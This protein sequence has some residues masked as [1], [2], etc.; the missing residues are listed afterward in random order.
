MHRNNHRFFYGYVVACAGFITWFIGWGAYAL[1]FGVFFKPLLAEFHWSR[2]EIS[3]AYSTAL[4]MQASL[5]IVMGWLTDRLGP[6]FVVTFFG[7]FLGW[8]FL[9]MSRVETLWQ[10]ILF[11]GVVGGIG[12]STLNIPIMATISRWFV[13]RRG[14]VTGLVQAGAGIGGFLLAPLSGW[15]IVHYGWRTASTILG[16]AIASLM[17][18]AGLFLI[19]DPMDIGLFPDGIRPETPA[20]AGSSNKASQPP[21]SSK[22]RMFKTAPFWMLA[23][24][25]AS[26]GY[27]RS[28]F[29]THIAVHVQDLGFSLS[30][31]AHILA[32]IAL[33]SI[34][35]RIGMGRLG[36]I[37]GTKRTVTAS[38]VLTSLVIL[39]LILSRRLWQFYMFGIF[40]GFGWGAIAVLRFAVTAEV[41][42]LASVGFIMGSLGFCESL[43]ATF[44]SYF[45]GFLFDRFG[46]YN[47]AFLVCF[48]VSLLGLTMSWR[49]KSSGSSL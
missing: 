17:I 27:F 10:F 34:I 11:Y 15:L 14:L 35:G 4:F 6:R 7:S 45:G 41:F 1:C 25:F 30:D 37:I 36:D 29:T 2:A 22:G 43:A 26:F 48:A 20:D 5:V 39:W 42:G 47:A 32:V 19:R 16:A 9:L 40:Y 3:L 24:V 38:F 44:G 23:I 49:L 21:G 31:G 33:V 18:L 8:A 28:T 13:K 46:N 12:A